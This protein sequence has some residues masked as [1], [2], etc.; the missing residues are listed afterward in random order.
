MSAKYKKSDIFSYLN[1]AKGEY[2]ARSYIM[3]ESKR[4]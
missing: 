2:L 1:K 3:F 4:F